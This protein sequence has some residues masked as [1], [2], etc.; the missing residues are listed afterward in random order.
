MKR[1]V[2]CDWGRLE[3]DG[4]LVLLGPGSGCINTAGEKVYPEEVEEVIKTHPDVSDALVVGIPDE[5]FGQRVTAVVAPGVPG[6]D[7]MD[8]INE[9]L[10]ERLAGY[11][12]PRVVVQVDAI[13][14]AANGKP[15]CPWARDAVLNEVK[16]AGSPA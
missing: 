12:R 9:Y 6:T 10:K 15:D 3:A 7:V 14:R 16:R 8:A 5:R 2:G 4:T 13:K 11:K 1:G